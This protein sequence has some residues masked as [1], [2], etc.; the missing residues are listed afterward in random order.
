MQKELDQATD[1]Y[2]YAQQQYDNDMKTKAKRQ[3]L[4]V[5]PDATDEEIEKIRTSADGRKELFRQM[6]LAGGVQNTK[7]PSPAAAA[8]TTPEHNQ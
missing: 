6:I 7:T 2:R 3:I 1:E 5:K 4:M 8:E